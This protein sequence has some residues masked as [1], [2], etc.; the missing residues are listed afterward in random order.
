MAENHQPNLSSKKGRIAPLNGVSARIQL[1]L[2]GYMYRHYVECRWL[3]VWPECILRHSYYVRNPI[4]ALRSH[5]KHREKK[6]R[7]SRVRCEP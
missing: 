4:K 5:G 6:T 7:G 3:S 2:S 1:K